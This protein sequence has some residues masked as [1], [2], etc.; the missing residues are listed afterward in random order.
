MKGK[1]IVT[2]EKPREEFKTDGFEMLM[3]AAGDVIATL[4]VIF[5]SIS[6]LSRLSR[7]ITLEGRSI[8]AIIFV[9]VLVLG[10]CDPFLRRHFGEATE[11]GRRRERA[12]RI[13]LTAMVAVLCILRFWRCHDELVSGFKALFSHFIDCVN[14]AYDTSH[15]AKGGHDYD[16]SAALCYGTLV[17]FFVCHFPSRR[18][19]R[20]WA[21]L[22]FPAVSIILIMFVGLP[23]KWGQI[24]TVLIG[25]YLISKDRVGRNGLKTN[26]ILLGIL[27]GSL[28]LVGVLLGGTAEGFLRYAVTAKAYERQIE[29]K[30]KAIY[31]KVAFPMNKTITNEKPQYKDKKIM[32]VLLEERPTGNLYFKDYVGTNYDRGSWKASAR[33]FLEACQERDVDSGKAMTYLYSSLGDN[34]PGEKILYQMKYGFRAGS[35]M[36]LPY[37]VNAS[38]VEGV[39]FK[40]DLFAKKSLMK[41][42]VTF[43][44]RKSNVF[45]ENDLLTAYENARAKDEQ[46]LEFWNWY[47]EYV[48]ETC[49][50][51]PDFIYELNC[52]NEISREIPRGEILTY[53]KDPYGRNYVFLRQ[54]GSDNVNEWRINAAQIV[55]RYLKRN[56]T[57]SWDLDQLE[58]GADPVEYF[59]ESGGRGYCVHFA[60]AGVLL[61]RSVGV[62][63]R[64]ACGYMVK[65]TAFQ[66]QEDGT[67]KAIVIDRN[68]H[69]WVE[70][71]LDN[72]GWIPVEMTPGYETDS[73]EDPTSEQAEEKRREEVA[74]FEEKNPVNEETPSPTVEPEATNTPAP[75][76][77]P[78]AEK[79]KK[80]GGSKNGS[81]ERDGSGSEGINPWVLAGAVILAVSLLLILTSRRSHARRLREAIRKRRYKAAVIIMN[82]R[83]YKKLRTKRLI[84]GAHPTDGDFEAALVARLGAE[85]SGEVAEYLRIVKEARFS[86]HPITSEECKTVRRF[87]ITFY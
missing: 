20:K 29:N 61:L 51:V 18:G 45:G 8:F 19:G 86:D 31:S 76:N 52:Y 9:D 28:V 87:V 71:Y 42:K 67:S 62:P 17:F 46:E 14:H 57:Y 44:G 75:T 39:R 48:Q 34:L 63:A 49:L 38:D 4:L 25:T 1:K 6:I 3:E 59:L 2:W 16:L 80:K 79:G 15:Y 24:A 74:T 5:A 26:L 43:Q 60:T 33:E 32:T 23:P 85:R 58:G 47:G 56:Y 84:K 82:R 37:G 36:L 81:V 53:S 10:F 66:K 77:E 65:T 73:A 68:G 21:F 40:E 13:G 35:S 70:I 41:G 55:S 22:A 30:V 64:Y 54:L 50:D 78:K 7:A 69:A 27:S 12:I 83:V 11:K 72:L